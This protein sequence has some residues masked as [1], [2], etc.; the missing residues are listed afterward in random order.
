MP[1]QKLFL[2]RHHAS[3]FRRHRGGRAP[4]R[5]STIL[6][7]TAVSSVTPAVTQKKEAL[8][9]I[10]P[11]NGAPRPRRR[12]RPRLDTRQKKRVEIALA[13]ILP[14]QRLL[15]QTIGVRVGVVARQRMEACL[16]EVLAAGAGE[17]KE[18]MLRRMYVGEVG[19]M[20]PDRC[21]CSG[22]RLV[23]A[24]FCATRSAGSRPK[25]W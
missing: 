2:R 23:C 24:P 17:R 21:L 12:S 5:L 8:T 7:R 18:N 4:L 13:M 3:P 22:H 9:E 19:V 10:G 14:C 11:K 25:L 6:S 20:M 16:P 1:F 15:L